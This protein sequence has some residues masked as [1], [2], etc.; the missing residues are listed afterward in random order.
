MSGQSDW[1]TLNH[2]QK[3]IQKELIKQRPLMNWILLIS[4]AGL[5]LTVINF[6]I[7]ASK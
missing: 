5:V 2:T 1:I 3:D 4:V 7:V 6:I